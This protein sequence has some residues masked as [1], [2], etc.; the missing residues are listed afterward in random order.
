MSI[1]RPPRPLS[2]LLALVL[3]AAC[4]LLVACGSKNNPHL[5]SPTR[6]DRLKSEL[7]DVRNAV[8]SGD[9]QAAKTAV[10]R[11]QDEVASLPSD[12]DPGLRQRLQEGASNLAQRAPQDCRQ[13]TQTTPTVTETVPTV[14][15]TTTT[16][17]QTTTATTTTPTQ[18]Q[19]TTT[20]TQTQTTPTQTTT[21]PDSG[22]STAPTP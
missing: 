1:P 18:T 6:A 15:E 9:C 21:T 17:T 14:T 5:F 19:T 22:G 2:L 16:P 11:L 3:G 7:D 13:N 10:K 20:P 4:A 12:I 8:D